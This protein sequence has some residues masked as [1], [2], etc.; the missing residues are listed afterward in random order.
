MQLTA[1]LAGI[2]PLGL[3]EVMRGKGGG[4]GG[5]GGG[6]R[7]RRRKHTEPKKGRK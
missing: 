4:G 6:N 7:A 1:V 2:V 3:Q 5:G